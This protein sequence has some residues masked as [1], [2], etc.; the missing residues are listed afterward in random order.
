MSGHLSLYTW[1]SVQIYSKDASDPASE[2]KA[3]AEI[4][5]NSKDNEEYNRNQTLQTS[6]IHL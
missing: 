1:Y 4:C 2:G 5:T 3:N 6:D